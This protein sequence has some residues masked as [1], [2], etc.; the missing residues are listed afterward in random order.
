MEEKKPKVLLTQPSKDLKVTINLIDSLI[1]GKRFAEADSKKQMYLL[2]C[3]TKLREMQEGHFDE[4]G[5]HFLYNTMNQLISQLTNA[6]EDLRDIAY[7]LERGMDDEF[8][9]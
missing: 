8:V 6:R 7:K 2:G 4:N 3:Q 5:I 1:A 9:Q